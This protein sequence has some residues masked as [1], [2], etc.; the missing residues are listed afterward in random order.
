MTGE[1]DNEPDKLS[2][3]DTKSG[4]QCHIVRGPMSALCGYVGIPEG[5]PYFGLGYDDIDISAHGGL[6]YAADKAPESDI[7]GVWWFGFDCSHAGDYLPKNSYRDNLG[8]PTGWGT[9]VTY[10]N[11]AYV[12]NECRN[13]ARD[14][15]SPRCG[16]PLNNS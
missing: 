9:Y 16:M 1:W 7:S 10:R 12:E 14:L 5:H 13:I 6:T 15:S 11:I 3:C 8:E 4:L 2:W